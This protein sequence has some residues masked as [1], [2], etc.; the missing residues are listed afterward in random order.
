MESEDGK[1][2]YRV[3][4][5]KASTTRTDCDVINSNNIIPQGSQHEQTVRSRIEIVG[6]KTV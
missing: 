3:E 6:F 1:Q 5:K 2:S 4:I